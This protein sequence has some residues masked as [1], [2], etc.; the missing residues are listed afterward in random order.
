MKS[1]SR[2]QQEININP[3]MSNRGIS[4]LIGQH[5]VQQEAKGS[6]SFMF[7]LFLVSGYLGICDFEI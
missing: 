7:R 4:P 1:L 2:L 5:F 6:M 3:D